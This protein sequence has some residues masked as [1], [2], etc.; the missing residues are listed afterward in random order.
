MKKLILIA[1]LAVVSFAYTGFMQPK[2]GAWAK[3]EVYGDD[4]E[5]FTMTTKFL[6]RTKYKGLD[7][8]V[9]E[10][11]SSM[12]NGFVSVVQY[13]SAV[14]N[15]KM[16]KK[17]ISKTPQGIM[18]MSE[19]MVGMMGGGDE[20]QYHTTTPKEFSPKM[21]NI[22]FGTYKL[23]NGKK[24]KVAIFKEGK[25]E[26]WVSSKVPFGMVLVK[27]NGKVVMR[28]I[29]YGLKGAKAKIPL[30]EAKNCAPMSLPIPVM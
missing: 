12:P 25:S 6:G 5:K 28:L 2:A 18:C 14:G 11:E 17:I 22:K 4:G 24:I 8:N 27:D 21:P 7:V 10:I 26:A 29:D 13:W 3:Y 23:P 15:D 1:L 16:V 30:K 9:V 19:E 20:A